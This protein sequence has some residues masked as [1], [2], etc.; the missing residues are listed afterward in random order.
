MSTVLNFARGS[1]H[2][3]LPK[4][5]CLMTNHAAFVFNGVF[6]LKSLD[7]TL[8]QFT[9]TARKPSISENKQQFYSRLQDHYLSFY[10]QIGTNS[11]YKL[12]ILY[13]EGK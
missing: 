8:I 9:L 7:G 3:V 11:T 1:L 4:F 12:R 13:L 5:K 6:T 10:S 2:Y